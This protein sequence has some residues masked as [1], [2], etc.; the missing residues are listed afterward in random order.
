MPDI[1]NLI[2]M[3]MIICCGMVTFATTRAIITER[4]GESERR[5][6]PVYIRPTRAIGPGGVS[7]WWV[8]GRCVGILTNVGRKYAE[9]RF[10]SRA[11]EEAIFDRVPLGWL[12]VVD[13]PMRQDDPTPSQELTKALNRTLLGR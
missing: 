7:R 4:G 5:G 10:R 9:V 11:G 8:D 2:M 13:G 1:Y 12:T 6:R 3:I